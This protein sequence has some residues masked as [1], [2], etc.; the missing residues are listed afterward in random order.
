MYVIVNKVKYLLFYFIFWVV[1]F[2]IQ[3]PIF[4]LFEFSQSKN[5]RFSDMLLT[6]PH[7]LP[8]D[9]SMAAYLCV[10]PLL[11][12]LLSCF[13]RTMKWAEICILR[14]TQLVIV[15]VSV[16]FIADLFLYQYWGFR[17]DSTPLFYLKTPKDAMAS[18]SW[19]EYIA[20]LLLFLAYVGASLYAYHWVDKRNRLADGQAI[21]GLLPLII[22]GALLFLAIRGGVGTSTM[23]A[24]RVYFSQSSFINHTA[25]NPIWNFLDSCTRPSDFSQQYRFMEDEKAVRLVR[26]LN[27]PL[28]QNSQY[29]NSHTSTQNSPVVDD[30]TPN[31]SIVD[32]TPTIV[33]PLPM[34]VLKTDRPNI[35]LIVMEGM[36][37]NIIETLGGVKGV[38]PNLCRLSEEGLLFTNFFANSF[39][40]DRGL[41]S[42][43]CGYPAQPTTSLMKF[44]KKTQNTPILTQRLHQEGYSTAFY[45][46]GDDNFTNLHSFLINGEYET[47]VNEND[48]KLKDMSTK[49]GAYDHILFE[50]VERDLKEESNHRTD[51]RP[52]F[53]TILTLNS[54][55]PFDVPSHDLDDPYLNSAH[56]ADSCIGGFV[57][58]YRHS[59]LWDNTL[60]IIMP[61]HAFRYPYTLNNEEPYRY[62]IPMLWIG[63]ALKT[64]CPDTFSS[65][66]SLN[67]TAKP[68]VYPH[69]IDKTC[70]QIDF[71]A[72][73]LRQLGISSDGFLFSH[74]ILDERHPQYAFFSY[75][76]G[77]GLIH[78]NDTALY[79]CGSNKVIRTTN[80]TTLEQGKAFLQKLYDD[81]SHR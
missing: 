46:G 39:R 33:A 31:D 34:K 25:I 42:I 73:L 57:E 24:G 28:P 80:D 5:E 64:T 50:K 14:Y 62:R 52:F 48:F 58:R 67:Y 8:M 27:T 69:F 6:I 12:V 2:V 30:G 11:F 35:I 55:E 21:A 20:A 17:I 10:V 61:D 13:T 74:D 18:A 43:L 68:T 19:K 32:T 77:F 16:I 71:T 41:V 79:N 56:Y 7:G 38:T 1:L 45:Y 9:F 65:I 47:I 49:W 72:T 53:K 63:G 4:L 76:D 26:L 36:G 78:R 23:N 70:G 15:I 37:S 81:L 3:K 29:N 60:I 75:N 44:P 22:V 40:T 51:K 66:D 59:E 54:H